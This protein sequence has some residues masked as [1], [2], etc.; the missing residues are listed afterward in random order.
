MREGFG[1]ALPAAVKKSFD[2]ADGRYCGMTGRKMG[3]SEYPQ[4]GTE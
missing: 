4:L 1:T 3:E 2:S